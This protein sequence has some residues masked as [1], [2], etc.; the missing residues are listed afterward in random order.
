MRMVFQYID[1]CCE[2]ELKPDA[3][4]EAKAAFRQVSKVIDTDNS[5][6]IRTSCDLIFLSWA[7]VLQRTENLED[8]L[9]D[10]PWEF[11]VDDRKP[12]VEGLQ[13]AID[14]LAAFKKPLGAKKYREET[15]RAVSG[16]ATSKKTGVVRDLYLTPHHM[17]QLCSM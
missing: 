5:R 13:K 11:S 14:E 4:K 9:T 8:L 7:Q 1:R 2:H 17:I 12:I 6:K 15:R 16:L 3:A 10:E